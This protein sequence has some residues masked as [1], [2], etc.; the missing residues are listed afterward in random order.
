MK[1]HISYIR[2]RKDPLGSGLIFDKRLD[3]TSINS[4]YSISSKAGIQQSLSQNQV[5]I[6]TLL[7]RNKECQSFIILSSSNCFQMSPFNDV[8]YY[9]DVIK[10]ESMKRD[11]LISIRNS[12]G[13]LGL[14]RTLQIAHF[15]LFYHLITYNHISVTK[16][17]Q[18]ENFK[19]TFQV[20]KYYLMDE[21]GR[22]SIYNNPD[23]RSNI[24]WNPF[25]LNWNF[26][27]RNYCE[28]ASRIISLGQFI[29]ENLCIAKNGLHLKLGQ[30]QI[31]QI[32]SIE[33]R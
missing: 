20:F 10:K 29:C 19:Q 15:Y 32:D 7:K 6:H 14:G 22:V 2:K 33:I 12:L 18:L 16:Y 13:S 8:K 5:T 24:V 28:K 23:L 11:S 3:R 30:V 31:V 4:I 17:L 26:L 1:S 21:N 25:N 9:N 27:H